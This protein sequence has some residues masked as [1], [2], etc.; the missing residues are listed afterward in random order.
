MDIRKLK[1]K[2]LSGE[3]TELGLNI[4]EEAGGLFV[5]LFC[6][7]ENKG[8]KI[9]DSL[10]GLRTY[11]TDTFLKGYDTPETRWS[12]TSGHQ[13][14]E[15][16]FK[17]VD[18]LPSK[19]LFSNKHALNWEENALNAAR[20]GDQSGYAYSLDRY[21]EEYNGKFPRHKSD[22]VKA[23]E[24]KRNPD[25]LEVFAIPTDHPDVKDGVFYMAPSPYLNDPEISEDYNY[26]LVD[27]QKFLEKLEK[28]DPGILVDAKRNFGGEWDSEWV[29]RA[30]KPQTERNTGTFS[31]RT[32]TETQ[33]TVGESHL[34]FRSKSLNERGLKISSGDL[35]MLYVAQELKLPYLPI[36]VQTDD[37]DTEALDE[38]LD[39][40][41]YQS[42]T[43]VKP[44]YASVKPQYP[45]EPEL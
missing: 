19:I 17:T 25:P 35:Y 15:I 44:Q 36:A 4:Q 40:I 1:F 2:D 43:V 3:E 7:A 24:L 9:A 30:N 23:F 41:G 18:G 26:I 34:G 16:T 32:K 22:L 12:L 20:L 31:Y 10:W 13:T 5:N 21:R 14:T 6:L 45:I 11:I 8:R 33:I 27:T 28:D 39:Q 38:L 42:S 37:G 29:Q